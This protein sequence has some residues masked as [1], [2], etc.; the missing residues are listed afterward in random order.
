DPHLRQLEDVQI[1]LSLAFERHPAPAEYR[2]SL[3]AP[4]FLDNDG[5]ARE[6]RAGFCLLGFQFDT[7]PVVGLTSHRDRTVSSFRLLVS[8]VPKQRT[9]DQELETIQMLTLP[10][11][12][13][14]PSFASASTTG[15]SAPSV[16]P[17]SA[18]NGRSLS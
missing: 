15:I 8:N 13:L 3:G 10:P 11:F 2:N 14:V 6:P 4:V 9:R 18:A 1:G 5:G 16:L 17:T 12:S 7:M